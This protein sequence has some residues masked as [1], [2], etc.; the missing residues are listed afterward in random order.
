[1]YTMKFNEQQAGIIQNALNFYFRSFLGQLDLWH[2]SID[3]ESF[4]YFERNIVEGA[5]K[6]VM[7]LS[8]N[9]SYGINSKEIPD[10]ARDAADIRG[11]IRH[12]LWKDR[13]G[14]SEH[15][16]DAS[17]PTRYGTLALPEIKR[18][19]TP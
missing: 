15:T 2:V 1:M 11:V 5:L 13:E 8:Q 3:G 18:E 4:D 17:P 19:D 9:S 6:N 14:H 12:Q 10:M 16:V 7:K